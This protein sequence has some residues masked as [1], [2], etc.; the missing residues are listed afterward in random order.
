MA[1]GC[2]IG[3]DNAKNSEGQE[4]FLQSYFIFNSLCNTFSK[5]SFEK[6]I[7]HTMGKIG[8]KGNTNGK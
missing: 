1:K 3:F 2:Q 5:S 8:D 6:V 4:N 7:T